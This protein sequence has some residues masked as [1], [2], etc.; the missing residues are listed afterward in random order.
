MSDLSLPPGLVAPGALPSVSHAFT[1]DAAH[2]D[3]GRGGHAIAGVALHNTM[4]S[5]SRAWLSTTSQP[6]VSIHALVFRD[7]TRYSI[8]APLDTAWH[9][10]SA[11]PGFTNARYLGVEFEN[12]SNG[13]LVRQA[14]TA[15]QYNSGA[16]CVAGWLF[17]FGLVWAD[18][19][20]HKDIALPAGR[21][22]DP[23]NFDRARLQT[24]TAAWVAFFRRLPAD[25]QAAWII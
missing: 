11:R 25:Q 15:E 1:A 13:L 3:T 5:D 12:L 20:D 10:G 24:E 16:H 7:G 2:H 21:R 14:Y 18:V 23:A 6:P 19:V 8:V 4:G 9:V 22:H 17:S